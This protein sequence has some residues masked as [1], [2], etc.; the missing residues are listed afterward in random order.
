MQTKLEESFVVFQLRGFRLLHTPMLLLLW[1]D[2]VRVKVHYMC[3]ALRPFKHYVWTH[4]V[5]SFLFLFFEMAKA[6]QQ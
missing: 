6:T 2:A 1:P 4:L 5:R 3:I